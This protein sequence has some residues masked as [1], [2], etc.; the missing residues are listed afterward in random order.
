M[1]FTKVEVES[2]ENMSPIDFEAW[3]NIDHDLQA[4]AALTDENIVSFVNGNNNNKRKKNR[5]KLM[6]NLSE[7]RLRNFKL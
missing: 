2:P 5:I 7:S 4:T 6:T 1:A 3:V